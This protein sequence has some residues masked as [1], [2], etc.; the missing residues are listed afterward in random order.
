VFVILQLY[1]R[2]G[3]RIV[4]LRRLRS[5]LISF[6]KYILIKFVF[7]RDKVAELVKS[8]MAM[9]SPERAIAGIPRLNQRWPP[10]KRRKGQFGPFLSRDYR[11]NTGI[12]F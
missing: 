6:S 1:C 12:I 9:F 10:E 4:T 11:L 2:C 8:V 3:Y 5:L 7:V